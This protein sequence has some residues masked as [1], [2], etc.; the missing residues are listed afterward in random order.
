MFPATV[1]QDVRKNIRSSPRDPQENP[2]AERIGMDETPFRVN[3]LTPVVVKR[4]T[5]VSVP[6]IITHYL[7]RIRRV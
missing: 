6:E 4:T 7:A 2:L 3:S 5:R 1:A